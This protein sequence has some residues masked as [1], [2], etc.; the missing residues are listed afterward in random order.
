MK[1]NVNNRVS[2]ES[3]SSSAINEGIIKF[4]LLIKN[5][6]ILGG[7]TWTRL[8]ATC[9]LTGRRDSVDGMSNINGIIRKY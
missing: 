2:A 3:Q 6:T 5:K 4:F 7:H 9:K 1:R 8:E